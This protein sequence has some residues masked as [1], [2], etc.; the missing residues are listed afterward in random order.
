MASVIRITVYVSVHKPQT[1]NTAKIR[2]RMCHVQ[3]LEDGLQLVQSQSVECPSLHVQLY[4]IAQREGQLSNGTILRI[5]LLLLQFCILLLEGLSLL[6]FKYLFGVLMLLHRY[7]MYTVVS[8]FSNTEP[9]TVYGLHQFI[10]CIH[11]IPQSIIH[12]DK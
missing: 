8:S 12:N 3:L 4:T 11:F 10:T 5:V 7:Y 2:L 9:L 1:A 6:P